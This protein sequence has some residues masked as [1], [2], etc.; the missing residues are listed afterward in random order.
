MKQIL[1][2]IL[3]F[4]ISSASMGQTI[5]PSKE[6]KTRTTKNNEKGIETPAKPIS[7][8]N[9]IQI[10]RPIDKVRVKKLPIRKEVEISKSLKND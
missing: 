8:S 1:I 7:E 10:T 5:Q 3:F 6:V 2:S 4:S 9:T